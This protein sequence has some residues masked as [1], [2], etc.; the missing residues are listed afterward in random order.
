MLLVC[1]RQCEQ[2][3]TA[4]QLIERLLADRDNPI[5]AVH[6]VSLSESMAGGGGPACL[7]LRIPVD[8]RLLA[9]MPRGLAVDA[10]LLDGLRNVIEREYPTQVTFADLAQPDF[11]VHARR[12]THAVRELVKERMVT[13]RRET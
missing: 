2:I 7:R 11:T 12:A 1:P 8:E 10:S 5:E 4:H 3:P 9:T 13:M 6:Y